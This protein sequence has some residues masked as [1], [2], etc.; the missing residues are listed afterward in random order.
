MYVVTLQEHIDYDLV[1]STNP[2]FNKAIVRVNIFRQHRQTIQVCLD[3]CCVVLT[4]PLTLPVDVE[5]VLQFGNL[6]CSVV[7]RSISNHRIMKS[8]PKLNYW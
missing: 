6:K 2:A 3:I 4:V 7:S 1:E 8:L 5:P